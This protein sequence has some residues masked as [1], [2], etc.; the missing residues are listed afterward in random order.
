MRTAALARS[1]WALAME[2]RHG[3]RKLRICSALP[4]SAPQPSRATSGRVTRTARW[5]AVGVSLSIRS[6]LRGRAR[7]TLACWTGTRCAW[8]EGRRAGIGT[9]GGP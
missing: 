8:V 9:G 6:A 2:Q 5:E 7:T 1:K 4:P 3:S